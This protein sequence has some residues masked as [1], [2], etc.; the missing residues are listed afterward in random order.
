MGE[1]L[2]LSIP[3]ALIIIVIIFV[4]NDNKKRQKKEE[5]Q[6]YIVSNDNVIK[7]QCYWCKQAIEKETK[8]CPFCKKVPTKA[9]N[10]NRQVEIF[11]GVIL[12]IIAFLL[13]FGG[14]GIKITIS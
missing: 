9:G 5:T 6:N 8:I 7:Q 4:I 13:L 10:E 11:V 12:C 1:F 3:T 2:F 14:C